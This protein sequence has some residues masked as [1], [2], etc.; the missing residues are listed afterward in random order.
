M[1][2]FEA[3]VYVGQRVEIVSFQ[4]WLA[5]DDGRLSMAQ[6]LVYICFSIETTED[7]SWITSCQRVL[8]N[9]GRNAPKAVSSPM[10]PLR[11]ATNRVME[12]SSNDCHKVAKPECHGFCIY[13][14]IKTERRRRHDAVSN[15]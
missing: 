12:H 2:N 5:I 7:I 3:W 13:S 8:E 1:Y 14:G 10:M 11:K 9:M 6:A 4:F 15:N